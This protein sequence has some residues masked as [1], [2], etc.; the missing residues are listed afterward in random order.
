L[1]NLSS[2][3]GDPKKISEDSN[4]EK[5]SNSEEKIKNKNDIQNINKE[6]KSKQ[7]KYMRSSSLSINQINK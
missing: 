7:V 5:S 4:E 2:E 3:E 6:I 1:K